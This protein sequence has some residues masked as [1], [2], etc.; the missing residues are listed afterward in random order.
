MGRG[1][2]RPPAEPGDLRRRQLVTAVFVAIG[3][4][5]LGLSCASSPAARGSTPATLV[6]AGVWV[7]GAFASGPLHLGSIDTGTPLRRP[8]IM[9]V[10]IGLASRGSSSSAP[11][12]CARWTSRPRSAASSTADDSSLV[13]PAPA[14]DGRQRHRRG[15]L[16]PAPRTPPPVTLAWTTLAYIR[17]LAAAT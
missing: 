1:P 4:L 5:V 2:A 6:L 15:V 14:R 16:H 17:H 12:S 9:P 3:G 11:R 8:V 10:A 7:V 13:A